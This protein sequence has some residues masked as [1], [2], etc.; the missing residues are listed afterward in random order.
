MRVV[1]LAGLQLR[2]HG[3]D[4]VGRVLTIEQQPVKLSGR[5]NLGDK[6]IWN[7]QPQADIL[8]ACLERCLELVGV[9]FHGVNQA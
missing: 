3:P 4:V 7:A 2:Q 5:A 9:V 6:S 8:L 1:T